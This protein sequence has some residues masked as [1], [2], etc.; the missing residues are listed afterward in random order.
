MKLTELF[1]GFA[2]EFDDFSEWS[3]AAKAMGAV[4]HTT[5]GDKQKIFATSDL[6]K[7]SVKAFGEWNEKDN[8]GYTYTIR[9]QLRKTEL[10]L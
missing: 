8:K 10:A 4:T 9:R 3:R 1:E 7:P 6:K 5:T 2:K